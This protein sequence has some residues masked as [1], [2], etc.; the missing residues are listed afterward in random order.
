MRPAVPSGQP[1]PPLREI[2]A[3]TAA[4]VGNWI[5]ACDFLRPRVLPSLG[6]RIFAARTK[7]GLTVLDHKYIVSITA[8][9]FRSMNL[10][11]LSVFHGLSKPGIFNAAA[12]L[13]HTSQPAV[14]RELR[15]LENRLGV[16]LFAP[17]PRTMPL[18]TS[19]PVLPAHPQP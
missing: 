19:G 1:R 14:S 3:A 10:R 12:Q 11:P 15:T 6:N 13:L 18:T 5:V 2:V 17:L 9:S 4:T 16:P 7:L 8:L